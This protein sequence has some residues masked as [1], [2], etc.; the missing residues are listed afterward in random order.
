MNSKFNL[1]RAIAGEPI[2]TMEGV[3]AEFVAYR[4]TVR[5][6]S[7]VI[8]QVEDR[9]IMCRE[10]G[11]LYGR[12]GASINDLR[13]KSVVKQIDWAKLPVDT[14]ITLSLDE[15]TANRYFSSFN[16]GKV[17]YYRGGM[18]LKTSVDSLDILTINPSNVQIAPD[19]PWTVWQGGDC[20]L[21]DGLGFEYVIH[22]EPGQ[23][24]VGAESA[25]AYSWWP[26]Y[27]YRPT[28]K[29][30]DGWKL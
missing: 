6:D 13:M 30:L 9:L 19:Q 7:R 4:P 1:Q 20:P 24:M 5:I 17:Y 12:L 15:A 29:I 16:N 10:D 18:S 23:V 22:N 26:I 21:P 11:N 27:A 25:S 3:H 8:V 28:G 2:E 14:L